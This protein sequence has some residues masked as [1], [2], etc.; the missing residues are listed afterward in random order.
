MFLLLR[1]ALRHLRKSPGFAATAILTLTLGH[2]LVDGDLRRS[3]CGATGAAA[4]CAARSTRRRG[5]PAG[6]RC[7]HPN[8]AGLSVAF[9]HVQQ[10]R[11]ISSVVAGSEDNRRYGG[12]SDSCRVAGLLLDA[13]NSFR[14]GNKLADHGE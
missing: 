3:R 4:L 7:F 9:D 11:C 1:Y 6:P 13:G 12:P 8:D 2:W 10:S 14:T 5:F